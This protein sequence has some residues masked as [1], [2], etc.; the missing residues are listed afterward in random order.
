MAG[1]SLRHPP[2]VSRLLWCSGDWCWCWAVTGNVTRF[3]TTI[4]PKSGSRSTVPSWGWPPLKL[5]LT[6]WLGLLT[7]TV[8]GPDVWKGQPWGSLSAEHRLCPY[9]FLKSPLQGSG[10]GETHMLA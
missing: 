4:A 5:H 10:H 3:V 8:D 6:N 7:L 1:P 9:R 2:V